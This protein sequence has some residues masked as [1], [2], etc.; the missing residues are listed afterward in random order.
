MGVNRPAGLPSRLRGAGRRADH[1]RPTELR[2]GR[3]PCAAVVRRRLLLRTHGSARSTPPVA[4]RESPASTAIDRY[5]LDRKKYVVARFSPFVTI[6]LSAIS[7]RSGRASSLVVV[8]SSLLICSI[9]KPGFLLMND[10][11]F[12]A[13]FASSSCGR[14]APLPRGALLE[15]ARAPF[16]RPLA[17]R[18][19][20]P[21]RSRALPGWQRH[22]QRR[23]AEPVL[24]SAALLTQQSLRSERGSPACTDC[25]LLRQ[26]MANRADRHSRRLRFAPWRPERT[27]YPSSILGASSSCIRPQVR[28]PRSGSSIK[29]GSSS[30]AAP[31][32]TSQQSPATTTAEEAFRPMAGRP[33]NASPTLRATPRPHLGRGVR[34]PPADAERSH[35]P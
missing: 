35:R 11:T 26:G 8:P 3:C 14:F 17:A 27:G 25:K 22:R 21:F 31:R 6:T 23:L 32:R 13:S 15:A 20:L 12:S 16:A 7:F 33:S 5:F 19:P 9:L 10:A 34:C 1:D 4:A 18:A 2:S 30:A 28:H 24:R 29:R